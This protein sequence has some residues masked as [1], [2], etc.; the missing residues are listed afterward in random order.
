MVGSD[1]LL[2]CSDM[3]WL[4]EWA[5]SLQK[6]FGKTT[7]VLLNRFTDTIVQQLVSGRNKQAPFA[8]RWHGIED[9]GDLICLGY[10]SGLERIHANNGGVHV[11]GNTQVVSKRRSFLHTFRENPRHSRTGPHTR[12]A[13]HRHGGVSLWR[14]WPLVARH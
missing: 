10:W 13:R 7:A 4:Q 11:R 12:G 2:V 6:L 14:S 1:N 3:A 5:L 9:D 8:C